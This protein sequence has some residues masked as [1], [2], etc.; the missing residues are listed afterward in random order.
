MAPSQTQ[1]QSGSAN[2]GIRGDQHAC[3]GT[4][5]NSQR[6]KGEADQ[7]ADSQTTPL[8]PG[9]G[10]FLLRNRHWRTGQSVASTEAPGELPGG[11]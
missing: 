1:A 11:A 4:Q 9:A 7:G 10:L 2:F 3:K 5:T 6:T 8:V